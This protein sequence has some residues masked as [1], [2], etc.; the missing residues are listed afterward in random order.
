MGHVALL[1]K[2]QYNASSELF[3]I[4]KDNSD[5]KKVISV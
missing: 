2:F 1:M 3:N 5:F 4:Y